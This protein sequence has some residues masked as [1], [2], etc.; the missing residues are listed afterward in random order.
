MSDTKPRSPSDTSQVVAAWWEST[1]KVV[2]FTEQAMRAPSDALVISNFNNY[3]STYCGVREGRNHS[4]THGFPVD[5]FHATV[6]SPF[7]WWLKEIFWN[8]TKTSTQKELRCLRCHE[9]PPRIYII[10]NHSWR[11]PRHPSAVLAPGVHHQFIH[12]PELLV[13]ILYTRQ[14]WDESCIIATWR[15]RGWVG[16]VSNGVLKQSWHEVCSTLSTPCM[17][18]LQR[19]LIAFTPWTHVHKE[20]CKREDPHQF[21]NWWLCNLSCLPKT[22]NSSRQILE[23]ANKL[24]VSCYG[25]SLSATFEGHIVW[26]TATRNNKPSPN[27]PNSCTSTS[28]DYRWL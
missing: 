7:N 17:R 5:H 22:V 25:L 12:Q 1:A 8:T 26:I 15:P 19:L 11:L 18:G 9:T 4:W 23:D 28:H 14:T 20:T 21:L 3:T 2:G 10:K 24:I 13:A 6:A 16:A 27:I